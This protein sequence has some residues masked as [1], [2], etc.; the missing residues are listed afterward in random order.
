MPGIA[1]LTATALC[2][3][4]PA[5]RQVAVVFLFAPSLFYADT[6]HEAVSRC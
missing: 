2:E 6:T 5:L 1:L 4:C 3:L